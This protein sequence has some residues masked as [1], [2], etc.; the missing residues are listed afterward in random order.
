MGP[1]VLAQPGVE[2]PLDVDQL[3]VPGPAPVVPLVGQLVRHGERHHGDDV[4]RVVALR[5]GLDPALH[6]PQPGVE[7]VPGGRGPD[8]GPHTGGVPHDVLDSDHGAGEEGPHRHVGQQGG[9]P[10]VK[11]LLDVSVVF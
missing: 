1:A 7:G 9:A 5:P 11:R 8:P 2:R 3:G 10:V 6:P 4:V